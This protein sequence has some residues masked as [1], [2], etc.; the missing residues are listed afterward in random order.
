VR[1]RGDFAIRGGVIDLFP[2]ELPEPV[3]LDLFGDTLESI[4]SF[5]PETQRSTHQLQGVVLAPVSEAIL[6][7]VAASRFRLGYLELF[8]AAQGDPLYEAVT[9]RM[10]RNGME[11][12]LPLFH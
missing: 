4:R 5:D 9:K 8:G 6:D 11:H 10:R 7:D 1:E 2:P 12:W 3:R